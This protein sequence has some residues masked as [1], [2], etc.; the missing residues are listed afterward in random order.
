MRPIRLTM[1]A[2]GP[3]ASTAVLELDRL[4][5]SG[6]YL[7]T[8]DT[9]AGKTTI[10]DAIVFALYGE[11]SGEHRKSSMLRSQYADSSTP[12]EV[13]LLFSYHGKEYTVK[14][15]PEYERPKS[16]GE[17]TTKML[18][19]A[20][21]VYPDGR[22]P[23]S[24][25]KEVDAAIVEIMGIN[26]AQFLQIAMIA[27]G[28]FLKLLLASTEERQKIFQKIFK[29]RC[30]FT[31][32][33]RLKKEAAAL[34]HRR[35][36]MAAGIRQYIDGIAVREEDPLFERVK[37][38]KEGNLPVEETL[39]LLAALLDSALTREAHLEETA[40]E[41]AAELESITVTLTK[42]KTW[43]D[44]RRSLD[45]T[46][47]GLEEAKNEKI[48]LLERLTEAEQGKQ[49]GEALQKE[50]AAIEAELP[51]YAEHS[52]KTDLLLKTEKRI[53]DLTREAEGQTRRR[54]LLQKE[55]E[56]VEKE[57]RSLETADREKAELEGKKQS[58][59]ARLKALQNAESEW[60]ALLSLEEQWEREKAVYREA[61]ETL[62]RENDTYQEL[63]RRYLDE[64]AGILAETLSPGMPCPV[65]GATSHPRK[66][67]RS[68]AA[69]TKE[70]LDESKRAYEAAQKA[71][72]SASE[73]A[74]KAKGQVEE[75]REGVR[76]AL[77]ELLE[78][79]LPENAEERI[80]KEL[81]ECNALLSDLS[82]A[83]SEAQKRIERKRALDALLSQKR[84]E[85][86]S[87]ELAVR[88]NE[89]ALAE[90]R[91]E[92]KGLRERV[93]ALAEKLRF[94]GEKEAR[95]ALLALEK[96]AGA[97]ADALQK[98]NAALSAQNERIA[99]L[100][101]AKTEAEKLLK[102]AKEIDIAALRERQEALLLRQGETVRA[103]KQLHAEKTANETAERA[104]R[105]NSESLV[106]LETR[107]S[108]VEAL[109]NTANGK[110]KGKEKILL[111]T[112]IQMA[113]FDRIVARANVR[114][115]A[116]TGGQYEMERRREET[117]LREKSGLD[118]DVFDHY[119]G[120][121]RSV[122]TLS[123]GES[124]K[125]SLSL[126]L[127]LSDEIQSQTGGIRLDTMFVDEGFGSLDDESLRGAIR[128]LQG[129]TEGNRLVGIIS[130]VAELKERID[131]QIVVT[132]KRSGGS[133]AEI[134]L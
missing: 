114:L 109:A 117:D 104:I 68:E 133:T 76:S 54:D 80:R 28:D 32:Q 97:L 44:A 78:G 130:H 128:T 107:V 83:I 60:R 106:A 37:E 111:E 70:A 121:R 33:E 26:R 112:Y 132:K 125:A 101:A 85:Q 63:F 9:G 17:G 6:L 113:Y 49:R 72:Q 96:E 116:M 92:A 110:V 12:T 62:A 120:T 2:F 14:R 131:R 66:A 58:A 81:K 45:A 31:L 55:T 134:R 8:G 69:P 102:D 7:I 108:W 87:L 98:A 119:N 61:A 52:A 46:R 41:I 5:E 39:C 122:A 3:Y 64:Q 43:D 38:A 79:A 124:F 95:E 118:L 19:G 51:E 105:E 65:C 91:T 20:T 90:E 67:T 50:C 77:C 115:L 21:L 99:G 40:K 94:Q 10:F 53:V 127:G 129:L 89:T 47:R 29:T 30:Y 34:A 4:G 84:E 48:R 36:T 1:S 73:R 42:Q 56:A 86:A 18:A 123:G 93:G 57:R 59:Q 88:E 15:N 35:E 103:Q 126:A 13:E 75:K 22:A 82:A 24:K 16:R 11:A 25:K 27:Q 74:A 71:A 100:E 23:L